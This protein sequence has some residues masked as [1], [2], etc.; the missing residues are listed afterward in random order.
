MR[1]SASIIC[2]LL[3]CCAGAG[4]AEDTLPAL[5]EAVPA[6]ELGRQSGGQDLTVNVGDVDILHNHLDQAA[7]A[8]SNVIQGVTT[9]GSNFITD[10]AFQNATGI[11][12][13]IQNT[14]NQVVI[15]NSMNM[16]ILFK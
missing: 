14:G 7:S 13:L 12:N 9:T 2:L 1:I 15:Q 11:V 5:S 16:N 4:H 8:D 6:A 3:V 10:N